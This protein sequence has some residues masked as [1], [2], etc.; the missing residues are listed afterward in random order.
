M[1]TEPDDTACELIHDHQDPVRF[2]QDRFG[3]E[4]VQTPEA[5][6]G[7]SKQGEPRRPAVCTFRLI[8]CSQNSTDHIFVQVGPKGFGQVLCDLRATKARIAPLDFA[9]GSDQFR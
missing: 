3:P 8:V 2:E 4:Q 6:L 1:N 9:D 5:V 7:M